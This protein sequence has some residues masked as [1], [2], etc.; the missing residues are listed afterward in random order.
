[1][2]TDPHSGTVDFLYKVFGEGTRLL[3]QRKVG[4]KLDILGP[5]GSPF[6]P[7]MERTRPLLIGGVSGSRP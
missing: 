7:H 2:R 5:I 1:M 4:E 6:V 3:S